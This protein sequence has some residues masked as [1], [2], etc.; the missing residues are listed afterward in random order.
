MIQE[1]EVKDALKSMKGG[2]T[3]GPD[4]IPIEV[5]SLGDVVIV[6]LTK[7][8]NLIFR[9]NKMTDEWSRS[10]LVPIFKKKG[11]VQSCTNY[12]GSN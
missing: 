8:F 5:W 12:R 9:S 10:I 11:D 3:M 6:W 4:E 1:S 7:L 2:K